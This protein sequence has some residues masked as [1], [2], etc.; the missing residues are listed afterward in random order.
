[1]VDD[2]PVLERT[3]KIKNIADMSVLAFLKVLSGINK[4]PEILAYKE[5]KL[6]CERLPN[7]AVKMGFGLHV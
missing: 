3:S 1:M 6:L 4:K 2:M 7:F 5:H